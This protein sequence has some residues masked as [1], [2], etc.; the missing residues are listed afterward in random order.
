MYGF[1]VGSA[2]CGGPSCEKGNSKTELLRLSDWS[3]SNNHAKYPYWT[4]ISNYATIM[5]NE[6]FL[7]FGGFS[8]QY[9]IHDKKNA[10]SDIARYDPKSDKWTKLG[11]LNAERSTHDV[12]ISGNAFLIIGDGKY[13]TT[14]TEACVLIANKDRMKCSCIQKPYIKRYH[15]WILYVFLLR[16]FVFNHY[17]VNMRI[18][19]ILTITL[20]SVKIRPLHLLR[21]RPTELQ[22]QRF[23]RLLIQ[24]SQVS[25]SFFTFY[26]NDSGTFL[27][28]DTA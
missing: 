1:A 13:R 7:I 27:P 16:C 8:R 18:C 17:K 23:S 3:W 2:R 4:D 24:S 10:K 25:M 11:N 14:T 6:M 12:I 20:I 9:T 21:L 15:G 19:S 22:I 26:L 5:H 28:L